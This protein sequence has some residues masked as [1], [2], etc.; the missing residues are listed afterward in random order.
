[1]KLP[2]AALLVTISLSALSALGCAKGPSDRLQGKW[3]GESIDNI[4]P[5]QEAKA[6][7]FVKRTSFEFRGDQLTVNVPAEDARSGTYKVERASGNRLT[8][9]VYRPGAAE[10]D[11]T[12]LTF[13]GENTLKWDIGNERSIKLARVTV[14]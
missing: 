12:T 1:M 13:V 8:L 10:P 7:G 4:P 14:Q 11:E 5:E 2:R 9:H 3:I 6:S